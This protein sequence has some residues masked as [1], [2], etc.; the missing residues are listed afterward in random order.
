MPAIRRAISATPARPAISGRRRLG[1]G[2][3]LE[4]GILPEHARLELAQRVSRFESELIPQVGP[5]AAVGGERVG[6]AAGPVEGQHQLGPQPL[7][8]RVRRGQ[9]LQLGHQL[10]RPPRL[11][12]DL[13]QILEACQPELAQPGNGMLSERLVRELR[14]RRTPPQHQ[15]L[16][17]LRHRG[18]VARACQAPAFGDQALEPVR[19]DLVGG[20][21]QPV[22]GPGRLEHVAAQHLPQL[23]HVHP[24]DLSGR[25]GRAL[26]P[27]LV[28]ET[29]DRYDLVSV[30]QEDRKQG[31]LARASQCDRAAI[32][33]DFERSQHPKLHCGR[34]YHVGLPPFIPD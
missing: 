16:A 7:S 33:L 31:A 17:E 30:Q 1:R 4:G 10:A 34:F 27:Q 25:L 19:V 28:D 15:R 11:E 3:G 24:H 8:L 20:R 23:R 12:F 13:V 21:A 2:A 26:G 9:T 22:S 5:Q 32:P 14:E 18:G 6:L 29:I